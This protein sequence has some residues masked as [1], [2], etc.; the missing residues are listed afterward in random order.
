MTGSLLGTCLL[1]SPKRDVVS[2]FR[3][4]GLWRS[5]YEFGPDCTYVPVSPE[6]QALAQE[7]I[8]AYVAAVRQGLR[9]AP[10]EPYIAV[11]TL[12]LSEGRRCVMVYDLL[13]A[14]FLAH[15]AY[16]VRGLPPRGAVVHRASVR[17]KL[18]T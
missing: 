18:V 6:Q 11:E 17:A 4:I 7:R 2:R 15:G 1:F 14:R 13:S 3:H 12:P 5:P 10:N 16:T 8:D 9:P